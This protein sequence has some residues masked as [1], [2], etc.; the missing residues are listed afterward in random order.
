MKN[1]AH[2]PA[3]IEIKPAR[4]PTEVRGLQNLP[5]LLQT[6]ADVQQGGQVQG[7]QAQQPN[8]AQQG[9]GGSGASDSSGGQGETTEK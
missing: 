8:A 5:G 9:G 3:D 4:G 1:K 7:G 6:L 2:R